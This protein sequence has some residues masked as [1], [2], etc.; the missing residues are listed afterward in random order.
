[1]NSVSK[2]STRLSRSLALGV[3]FTVNHDS[4]PAPEKVATDTALSLSLDVLL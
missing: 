1:V 3:A 2:I 4:R